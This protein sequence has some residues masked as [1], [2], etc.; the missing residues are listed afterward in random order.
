MATTRFAGA[1]EARFAETGAGEASRLMR[2]W[3]NL[4]IYHVTSVLNPRGRDAGCGA[5]AGGVGAAERAPWVCARL[6]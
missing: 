4:P 5:D 6:H 3:H 1:G 2:K